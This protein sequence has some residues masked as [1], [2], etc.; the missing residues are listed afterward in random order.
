MDSVNRRYIDDGDG[1]PESE[2]LDWLHHRGLPRISAAD[3][4]GPRQRAVVIAPHPDDEVLSVGGLMTQLGR[5]NRR[6][7]LV[8][9]TDGEAS[10]P[11]SPAWPKARLAQ[12]R[13]RETEAALATLEVDPLMMRLG[14]P[15]GGIADRQR[16]LTE[17]LTTLLMPDDVVFTTWR[18]DGHPDHEATALATRTAAAT[19]GATVFEVPVWGWHWARAGDA[20]MPWSSARLVTLG[21]DTVR[22]KGA[23]VEAFA[24]QTQP[25]PSAA[26]APV[27]RASTVRRAQRPFEVLFA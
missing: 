1:T 9:V 8:A 19:V 16:A 3:L 7:A 15:D 21:P 22:R 24:T 27:L 6:L 23:A 17:L 5:L 4:V 10:H 12:A 26:L 14:L 13:V 11:G 18:F 20:R 25:D 2:W